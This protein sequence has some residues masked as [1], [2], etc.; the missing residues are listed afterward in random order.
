MDEYV[1]LAEDQRETSDERLA[2]IGDQLVRITVLHDDRQRL[3]REYEEFVEWLRSVAEVR[4]GIALADLPQSRR[5]EL[6]LLFGHAAAESIALALQEQASLWTDDATVPVVVYGEHRSRR[7]WTQ[8]VAERLTAESCI[9]DDQFTELLAQLIRGGY[10]YTQCV[11]EALL[12]AAELSSWTP[13]LHPLRNVLQWLGNSDINEERVLMVALGG[14]KLVWR[15][16]PLVH[17]RE[18]ITL[19]IGRSLSGRPGGRDLVRG[20]ALMTTQLFPVQPHFAERCCHILLQSLEGLEDG[21]TKLIL[22]M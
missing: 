5:E 20:I 11:P 17:H 9:T 16:A 21:G 8:L 14:L 19:A 22:P 18:G 12:K 15:N 3:I 2:R 4:S 6:T 10:Q 13:E 7:T 1:R